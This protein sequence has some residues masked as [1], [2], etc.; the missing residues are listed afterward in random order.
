MNILEIIA[1]ATGILSIW[2][3]RKANIL[4]YPIGIISV[5][6]YVYICFGAKLYADMGINAFYFIL[7]VYGWYNWTKP[8]AEGNLKITFQ[9]QGHRWIAIGI[10]AVLFGFLAF[11]LSRFTDSDVPLI[12][13]FTSAL[14]ILGMYLTTQKKVENWIYYLIADAIS[15][16]LYIY[17]GLYFSS[18]QYA[19]FT[20]LAIMGLVEWRKEALKNA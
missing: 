5:L 12:D 9:N 17:K 15:I 10:S 18:I 6:L 7:N 11:I 4:V 19:V 8:R 20:I 14:C 1:A 2:F 3:N 16:P 13:A